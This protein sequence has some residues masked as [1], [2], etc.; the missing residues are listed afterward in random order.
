MPSSA[1]KAYRGIKR[2]GAILFRIAMTLTACRR[3]ENA[4]GSTIVT[5]DEADFQAAS[6]LVEAY[7]RHAMFYLR[8][9]RGGG[10]I[11]QYH[12]E[13]QA[14]VHR[15]PADRISRERCRGDWR[16]LRLEPCDGGQDAGNA[17]WQLFR[18]RP[19]R[20]VFQAV[21]VRILKS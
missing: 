3:F 20:R 15:K 2:L 1:Q 14:S 9:C 5:C 12:A 6:L 16:R 7:L 19:A 13:Q 11:L 4:D 8:N 17:D 21:K 18:L 10:V